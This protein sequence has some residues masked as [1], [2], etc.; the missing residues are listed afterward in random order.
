MT[1]D[2][3]KTDDMKKEEEGTTGEVVEMKDKAETGKK[4]TG[5]DTRTEE[6]ET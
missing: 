5:E 2:L 1:R 4:K 3:E 6:I